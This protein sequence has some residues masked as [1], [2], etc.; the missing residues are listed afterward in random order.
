MIKDKL[1]GCGVWFFRQSGH[2]RLPESCDWTLRRTRCYVKRWRKEFSGEKVQRPQGRK[3]PDEEQK[4][5]PELRR[6]E[7][8]RIRW[9]PRRRQGPIDA[10]PCW[11]RDSLGWIQSVKKAIQSLCS[12]SFCKIGFWMTPALAHPVFCV[13]EQTPSNRTQ[14]WLI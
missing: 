11:L 2:G 9:N 5:W 10:G 4:V 12:E 14:L 3:E 7:E 8:S 13:H 1:V 6:R